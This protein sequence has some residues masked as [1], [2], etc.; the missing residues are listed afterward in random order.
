[1]RKLNLDDDLDPLSEVL[2]AVRFRSTIFCRSDMTA[3]WG[4]S[5]AGREI[6]TF[7]FV[8]R[9]GCWLEVED[10]AAKT[11]LRAGDLVLLPHGHPHLVRDTPRSPVTRLDDL[12]RAHPVREGATLRFGGGG[13]PTTLICGGF[14]FDD[15]DALPFLS[16]L[17]PVVVVQ[18]GG[19]AGSWLRL[20]RETIAGEIEANRLGEGTILSRLSDLIF[21]EAARSYFS[22]A[23]GGPRGWFAALNDRHIGAA[24]SLIHRES[25]GSWTVASIASAVGMSRSAFA[26]RFSLL[27]GE[28]PMRYLARRRIARAS[29]LLE[30]QEL[31]IAR[32]AEKVGYESDVAFSRAFKRHVG[33][34]PADYRRARTWK[35]KA[36]DVERNSPANRHNARSR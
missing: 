4:F 11:R 25:H 8:E 31:T 20:A 6:A 26:L 33:L 34:S 27:L 12:L 29:S 23:S 19:R 30:A 17:P 21:I 35:K 9:G 36:R 18:E 28:S 32:I 7:H 5:V 16:A 22:D 1:M 10:A 24:I 13:A 14:V 15:R 3:P 2:G